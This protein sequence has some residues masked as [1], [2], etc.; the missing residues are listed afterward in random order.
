MI[1]VDTNVVVRLLV[2]EDDARQRRAAE[3][4]MRGGSV[5]LLQTVL[6]EIEWVLRSRYRFSPR[7]VAGGLRQLMA[8]PGVE[9]ENADR[10]ATALDWFEAGFDFADAMHLAAA[11]NAETFVSFDQGLIRRAARL[12]LAVPVREP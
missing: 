3:D 7:Q 5:R 9:V 8:L 1:L 12:G 11:G 2:D 6:M 4:V 10:V